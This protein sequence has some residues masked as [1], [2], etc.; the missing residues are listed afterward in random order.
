MNTTNYKSVVVI[1]YGV[2]TEKVLQLVRSYANV[3]KY[4]VEYIE[5]KIHEIN[6]AQKYVDA[7]ARDSFRSEYKNDLI[8]QL[9]KS[10][11][12]TLIIS[13]SNNYMFSSK[14][15]NNENIT[16]INFHN[17]LLPAYPGRNAPCWAIYAGEDKTGI[18]W[19]YVTSDISTGKVISQKECEITKDTKSC[20]LVAK[21]MGIAFEAFEDIYIGVLTDSAKTRTL[22]ISKDQRYY[23]SY[24]IPGEGCFSLEDDPE[25]IYRLLRSI[26][27]GKTN[28]LPYARTVHNNKL[29]YIKQYKIVD[30]FDE[31][32]VSGAIYLPYGEEHMLMLKYEVSSLEN[33]GR[34]VNDL[35]YLYEI[36][37]NLKSVKR[38]LDTNL[39]YSDHDLAKFISVG[40]LFYEYKADK[41]LN[42]I[43]FERDFARLY[44]YIADLEKYEVP[45]LQCKIVCDYF[46]TKETE[47]TQK[48]VNLLTGKGLQKYAVFNKWSKSGLPQINKEKNADII[49]SKQVIPEGFFEAIKDCFDIYTD[50]LP[51]EKDANDYLAGKICYSA[52]FK[53]SKQLA[54]G[55]VVTAKGDTFTE[56]F[57]F[58]LPSAR[59]LGITNDL[60]RFYYEDIQA[61]APQFYGWIQTG[62]R[63]PERML[64]NYE[65]KKTSSQ[66]I[67]F[68]KGF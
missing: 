46:Y 38:R 52:N 36:I 60:Y 11:E 21:L 20:E 48:V 9:S 39:Y 37:G 41:Y 23:K 53:S 59:G 65:Y 22:K 15:I 50:I 2:L 26:D 32:N 1:G 54:G 24:E 35:D 47:N 62:N 5:H 16:I 12:K 61:Q 45:E 14:L 51:E 43:I 29:I 8:A 4:Q 13:T 64:E 34:G 67:T 30:K 49:I 6:A 10:D 25:D 63:A 27:Y 40:K 56:E 44:F 17:A 7:D 31:G 55:L 57:L 18:T 42:L 66:K 3:Y 33:L 68:M 28:V 58:V 19:H